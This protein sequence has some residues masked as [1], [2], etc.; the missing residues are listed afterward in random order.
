M[1]SRIRY[2]QVPGG[3]EGNAEGCVELNRAAGTNVGGNCPVPVDL[4]N[5]AVNRVGEIHIA[6]GA[7]VEISG[8]GKRGLGSWPVIPGVALQASP[9][10]NRY[11]PAGGDLADAMLSD[12]ADEDISNCVDS[13]GI[14]Q[15]QRG[16]GSWPAVAGE[17]VKSV[18]GDG[19]DVAIRSKFADPAVLIVAHQDI[20][21]RIG[22][23]A[24]V[25]SE[26]KK[27]LERWPA[28]TG[29]TGGR[30]ATG[31]GGDYAFGVDPADTRE[32]AV[33]DE[34]VPLRVHSNSIGEGGSR[35][36][37]NAVGK[38]CAAAEHGGDNRPG[39]LA[40]T[41]VE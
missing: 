33:N 5:R 4:T 10:V 26:I 24:T 17:A 13:D 36:C 11:D 2:D 25:D 34:D 23:N 35:D 14:R 40:H 39:D 1:V 21:V 38:A 16:A 30:A 7:D 6:I 32:K 3:I 19:V 18:S 31:D 20:S 15:V 41:K 12:F 37:G 8:K 9:G 22:R 28:V 27:G 29:K